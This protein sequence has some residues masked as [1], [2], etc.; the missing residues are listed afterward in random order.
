MKLTTEERD[1]LK[2]LIRKGRIS[3]RKIAHA[4]ILIHADESRATGSLKDADI[5][6][7][8]QVSRL[9]VERVRKRFVGLRGN[10]WV[11]FSEER[12]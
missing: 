8:I 3:A 7:A 10:L 12:L 5:A 6:Q 1:Y 4:Q 2:Q 9:T 11:D